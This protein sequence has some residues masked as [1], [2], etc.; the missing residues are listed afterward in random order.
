MALIV[1]PECGNQASTFADACP[2][3]GFP[4]SRAQELAGAYATGVADGLAAGGYLAG[5]QARI[6]SGPD[7]SGWS[8][9]RK[10]LEAATKD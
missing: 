10:K 7:I 1:C 5:E 6:P 3:C 4:I 9:E 2:H 8:L